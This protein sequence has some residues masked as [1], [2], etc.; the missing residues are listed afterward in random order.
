M[1]IRFS[2]VIFYREDGRILIQDRR[3]IDKDDVEWGFFGGGADEGEAPIQ[4]A[5][6]EIRE[7]TNLSLV[8]DDVTYLW[9]VFVQYGNESKEGSVFCAPWKPEY[10]ADF[11]VLEG[12]GFAWVFPEE[13]EKLYTYPIL[14]IHI[15]FIK[16]YL[17]SLH[18]S[19]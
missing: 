18:D 3:N 19:P 8:S 17:I 10:E 13:M 1:H 5:L 16:K 2:N 6:R 7:E 9:K 15:S 11:C 14:H 4:T 12:A